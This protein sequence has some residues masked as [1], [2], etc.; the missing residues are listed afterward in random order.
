MAKESGWWTI[1][2]GE[3]NS[4]DLSESDLEQIG[5]MVREGY[6]SGEI[7]GNEE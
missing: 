5:E 2:F 6:T 3:L 1:D 7:V 4:D